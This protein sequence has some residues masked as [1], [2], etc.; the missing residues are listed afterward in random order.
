MH[1]I[2]LSTLLAGV[3]SQPLGVPSQPL[4][5]PRIEPAEPILLVVIPT[6]SAL[7]RNV[8]AVD[9]AIRAESSGRLALLAPTRTARA[10][11]DEGGEA[12]RE[13]SLDEAQAVLRRAEDRFREL[14]DETAL[15]LIAASTTRL[16][17][18]Q[19][20]KEAVFVLAQAHLLAAAIFLAR[21]RV[22]AARQRL[23]RALDL[24]REITPPRDRFAPEVLFELAALRASETTRPV[25]RLV[26]VSP[27][28]V[29]DVFI[30]GRLLG[31]TPLEL[32]T[33]SAGRHLLRLSARG[34]RSH[35]ETVEISAAGNHRVEA[36]L[37]RDAEL[38]QIDRLPE[39]FR[40][41]SSD[42]GDALQLLARRAG[43]KYVLVA[44]TRIAPHLTPAGTATTAVDLSVHPGG[45][46]AYAESLNPR[47]LRSALSRMLSCTERG[48]LPSSTA[49]A[50]LGQVE[51]RAH[52]PSPVP[53][54]EPW[55]NSSWFWAS[56][57]LAAVGLSGALV[58]VRSAAGPPD[59][60]E[61]TL[62]PRP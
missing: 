60:V 26:V 49:P 46:H 28:A 41:R 1:L 7:H 25:G 2:L 38:A 13:A 16:A 4:D 47:E 55:W 27:T 50:I 10:L 20:T 31:R 14:D 35:G 40:S 51:G 34:F 53:S 42:L 22:D 11:T 18:I 30:D 61:V 5:C 52:A 37:T 33:I 45:G 44:A 9:R 48:P 32:D 21:N 19:Q 12:E 8:G 43:V 62:V 23:Q 6:D 59:S 17:S 3:P 54:P 39:A 57:V 24:D 56:A 36:H 58:V 29:A 15:T